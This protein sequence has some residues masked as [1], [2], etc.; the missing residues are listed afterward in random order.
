MKV[1]GRGTT[2]ETPRTSRNESLHSYIFFFAPFFIQPPPLTN[3]PEN[4]PQPPQPPP[5]CLASFFYIIIWTEKKRKKQANIFFLPHSL[6]PFTPPGFLRQGVGGGKRRFWT[7]GKRNM[8]LM[9][10]ERNKL[11]IGFARIRISK[12]FWDL[13]EKY[14]KQRRPP[15]R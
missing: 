13:C 4:R 6:C 7:T 11:K 15:V 2:S 8:P 3:P 10:R 1:A 9:Y 12:F 14:V 5:P